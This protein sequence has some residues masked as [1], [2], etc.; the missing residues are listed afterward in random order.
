ML[1]QLLNV[2]DMVDFNLGVFM[3]QYTYGTTPYSFADFF[4]KLQNHERSLNYKTSIIHANVLKS[5]PSNTMPA[6]WNSLSLEIKRSP[7]LKL[8]KSRLWEL[9]S[10]KYEVKCSKQNCYTCK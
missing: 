10:S 2:N 4:F 6:L 5:I 7:T 1:I 9:L 8:F 3:Y